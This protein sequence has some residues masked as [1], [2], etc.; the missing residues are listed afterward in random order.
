MMAMKR[1]ALLF[2]FSLLAICASAVQIYEPFSYPPGADLAGHN[3]WVLTSGTTSPKV[4]A[5]SLAV[6]G[7]MPPAEGNSLLFGNSQM[8]IRRFMKNEFAPGEFP[9]YYWYSLAFKVT[10]LGSLNTNGDFIAA[11]SSTNQILEYGGRLYLRKDPLGTL[12]GYN[13]GVSR[14]S[15]AAADIVW[16]ANVSH[17]GETNF[18]VCR[19][20]TPDQSSTDTLL[21][22]NPDSSTYGQVSP[23]PPDLTASTGLHLLAAVGQFLFHQ[24]SA[25]PGLGAI[26]VDSLRVEG[27]WPYV[28]PVPLTMSITVTNGTDVYVSWGGHQNVFIQQATN[29]TPPITWKNLNSYPASGTINDWTVTNAVSDPVPKFFRVI[30]W[31]AE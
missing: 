25:N 30:A 4:Q 13:I 3:G 9:G 1:N 11:F 14:A 27:Q 22:I 2:A 28:T 16:S 8:E 19:Y 6:P 18:V 31:Y 26:L 12:N 15:G 7:L 5:G 21:W 10:D 17:V 23:P 24:A 20:A 29:L